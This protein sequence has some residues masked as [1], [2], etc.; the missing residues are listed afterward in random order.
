[1]TPLTYPTDD[2]GTPVEAVSRQARL[3]A[4]PAL[5]RAYLVAIDEPL[6]D[7]CDRRAQYHNEGENERLCLGCLGDEGDSGGEAIPYAPALRA[8]VAGVEGL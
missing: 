4:L 1:M 2:M 3:E 6:C 5:V 8:L 7:N